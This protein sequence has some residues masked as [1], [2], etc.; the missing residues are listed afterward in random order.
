[1]LLGMPFLAITNPDIDW[2]N[3]KFIGQI[4]VGTIDAYEWKPKQGSKKEGLFEP[5][6]NVDEMEGRRANY[7]TK[8]KNNNNTLKFTTFKPEDYTFI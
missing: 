6:E 4:Y 5:D 2:T 3:G 1:M 7:R 8:E